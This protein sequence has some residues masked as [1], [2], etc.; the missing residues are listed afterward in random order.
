MYLLCC[1]GSSLFIIVL[2]IEITFATA[3]Q[4]FTLYHQTY[5]LPYGHINQI[6]NATKTNDHGMKL[7][8]SV[9]Y[10]TFNYSKSG[11]LRS[12]HEAISYNS[13]KN[14]LI[15]HTDK[16]S[17]KKPLSGSEAKDLKQ[18][19]NDNIFKLRTYPPAAGAADY[20][21]YTIAV[22]SNGTKFVGSWT[23]A[24]KDVP[25][26]LLEMKNKIESI[27]TPLK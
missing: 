4:S 12:V 8:N 17:V 22:I 6:H 25:T 19:I 23:D 3:I 14:E 9:N 20:Y 18:T 13:N 10:F 1:K 15:I 5:G 2:I 27:S 11:G 24:S 26:E 7:P 16:A 21:N